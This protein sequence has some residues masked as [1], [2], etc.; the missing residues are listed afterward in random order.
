[1]QGRSLY[2]RWRRMERLKNRVL[3]RMDET[4]AAF[5]CRSDESGGRGYCIL[6]A[7]LHDFMIE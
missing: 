6:L 5:H 3:G 4:W 7:G 2:H 1:M